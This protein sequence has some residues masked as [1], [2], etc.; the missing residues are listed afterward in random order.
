L[1]NERGL[2]AK[3]RQTREGPGYSKF[4]AL[5]KVLGGGITTD[6]G[7]YETKERERDTTSESEL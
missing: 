4:K 3:L 5:Q 1:N 2:P 7:V 6:K